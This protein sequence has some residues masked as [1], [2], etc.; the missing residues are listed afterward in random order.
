MGILSFFFLTLAG[1]LARTR[2]P[3][4]SR[5]KMFDL[6]MFKD[7]KFLALFFTGG[8]T[9]FGFLVPFFL[10]SEYMVYIG[11]TVDQGALIVG[12]MN[13]AGAIGR[14]LMGLLADKFGRINL[15][16]L[17]NFISGVAV[18][19]IWTQAKSFAILVVFALVFGYVNKLILSILLILGNPYQSRLAFF[20]LY[21]FFSGGFIS[22]SPV[23][24]AQIFGVQ[25]LASI[26]GLVTLS[27]GIPGILG[28]PIATWQ[29]PRSRT[30]SA[31]PSTLEWCW[32][33]L[34]HA[35]RG[36]SS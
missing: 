22:L 26:Y 33:P 20:G 2:F 34:V 16:F 12:L 35:Q 15:L 7:L 10:M 19:V 1:I 13:G 18:L 30:M 3:P 21:S 23:V 4:P 28:T 5:G 29:R 8:F 36:S 9:Y 11:G 6:S 17:A 25:R 14:V 32:L 24:T 31:R 27:A